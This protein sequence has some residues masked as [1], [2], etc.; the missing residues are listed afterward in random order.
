MPSKSTTGS[1]GMDFTRGKKLSVGMGSSKHKDPYLAAKEAAKLAVSSCG[2]KPTFS[3][4]YTN[5]EYAQDKILNGINEVLGTSNWIGISTDKM[6]SSKT[7]H[8]KDL[9][10][11][12][13]SLA[14]DFMHFG[15]GVADNYRKNPVEAGRL[16]ASE[17]MSK[18]QVDKYVDAYI[19]F[20][21]TKT[22]DYHRIVRTPPYFMLAFA[23]GAKI[24]DGNS[25]PGNE[26]EFLQ[27]ILNYVGPHVPMFG[28]SASS[29]FEKYLHE[30]KGQN[31]Q[32]ANGKLYTDAAIVVF[33]VCNLYF[34]TFLEHGY[35]QTNNYASITKLDKTGYEI[36]EINGKEPVAEYARLLGISKKAYLQDPSKWS[37]TRPFG[38]VG[39]DGNTYVKEALPNA[40]SKTLHSTFKLYPN[41]VMNILDYDKKLTFTTI[42]HLLEECSKIKNDSQIKLALICSC[43]GRRPLLDGKENSVVKDAMKHF[44]QTLL[45]GFDSFGEIGSTYVTSPQCHSQ[46][47]TALVLWDSLL[48]E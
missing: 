36:L 16:A 46:T 45:F 10:V 26:S 38:L 20:T 47:V 9:A 12:V 7:G 35:T 3:L 6:F 44:S 1:K 32:F 11:T 15:I 4:V 40:D 37:L 48:T 19:Q 33:V 17:A 18:A 34:A 8:D 13:L 23:S 31:Y 2:K 39:I 24:I 28:G 22:H 43:S 14:S 25:I 27:G 29:S 42:S 5:S 21:R 30:N 41:C